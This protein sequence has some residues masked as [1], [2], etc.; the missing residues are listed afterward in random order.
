[1][2]VTPRLRKF[3]LTVHA[4]SSV[5]WLGAVLAFLALAIAG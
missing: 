5:D 4:T 3:A 1:M 2:T